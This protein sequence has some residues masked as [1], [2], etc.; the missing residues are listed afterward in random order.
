MGLVIEIVGWILL[1]LILG[2]AAGTVM[3]RRDNLVADLILG[4]VG[5]LL[6]GLLVAWLINPLGEGGIST[7]IITAAVV[8]VIFLAGRRA[9]TDPDPVSH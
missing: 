3:G 6:G 7:S 1:G 9:L 2:L 5:G 4:G 8:A